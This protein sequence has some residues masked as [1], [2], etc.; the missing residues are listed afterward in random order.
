MIIINDINN[1]FLPEVIII[2]F[3]LLNIILSLFINKNTYKKAKLINIIGIIISFISIAFMQITPTYF[4]YNNALLSNTYTIMFKI[5][6]LIS[7]ILVILA[8]PS[9]I[10]EKRKRTF[11]Y[12]SIIQSAILGSLLLISANDILT[13][14]ISMELLTISCYF[15]TGFRRNHKSK[16]AS[17]KYIITSSSATI[18]FLFGISYLYG[19]CGNINISTINEIYLSQPINILFTTASLL[20]ILGII[21]KLGCIPFSNWLI[22]I[23][24][25]STYSTCS[26]ISLIP[27]IAATAFL[28][29]L[30]VYIFQF[31][32]ILQLITA[33]IALISIVYASIGALKQTNIKRFYAYSS[34][35]HSG[36]ILLAISVANVY[37][38]SSVLF[39]IFTYIFINIGAWS[40][41]I[42]YNKEY[43]TDNIEDYKG[44]YYKHPYFSIALITSITALAG[45]PPTSGFIAK[46]YIFTA[47]ARTNSFYFVILIAALLATIISL[48]IYIKIIKVLFNKQQNTINLNKKFKKEK[49]ILYICALITLIICICPDFLIKI[50][51][52]TAYYI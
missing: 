18:L 41:S 25:G 2:I 4:S 10:R 20:I 33:I 19:L 7:A 35:I 17:L 48:L 26:F 29:R 42:I 32:P 15:L 40:A 47:I 49:I 36:F 45:L 21:F 38:L 22:D 51:Q 34:I 52:I 1:A 24:E 31:S 28:S 46:L 6:I 23:Y 5:M 37:S 12:F 16:E 14:F 30:F 11:E 9:M 44:L 39:Y 3:I 43:N 8:S 13:A 27:K 50:S